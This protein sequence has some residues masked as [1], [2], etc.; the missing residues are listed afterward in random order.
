MW[1]LI[2]ESFSDDMLKILLP[3]AI[4]SVI[5]GINEKGM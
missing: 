1:E 2:L 5:I 3:A 4:V